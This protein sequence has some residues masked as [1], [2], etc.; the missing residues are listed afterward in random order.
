MTA[1]ASTSTNSSG[2]IRAGVAIAA[3]EGTPPGKASLRLA[4]RA[5]RCPEWQTYFDPSPNWKFTLALSS[6]FHT[7]HSDAAIMKR[8]WRV[9]V[10]Y[11]A[12]QSGWILSCRM[13]GK[14]HPLLIQCA[15]RSVSAT[16]PC[17]P[18][19]LA[20]NESNDSCCGR[21]W[22]IQISQLNW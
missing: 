4:R 5:S 7:R 16:T 13:T 19:M 18:R 1:M 6:H 22:A 11:A 10:S 17:V 2:M 8:H 9:H 3:L 12:E 14:I 15:G 21:G 20:G